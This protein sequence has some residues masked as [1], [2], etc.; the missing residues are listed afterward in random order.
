LA[1]R[2]KLHPSYGSDGDPEGLMGY[3]LENGWRDSPQDG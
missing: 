1:V 3:H 2:G